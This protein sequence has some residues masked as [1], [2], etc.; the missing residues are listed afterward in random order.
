MTVVGRCVVAALA[1][2]CTGDPRVRV[3]AIEYGRS[4][5]FSSRQLVGDAPADERRPLSWQVWLI[6]TSD[7]TILVD[8]GF[9][10]AERAKA[11]RVTDFE[12]VAALVDP[13]TITDVIV[14]HGHWDHAGGVDQFPNA[15]VWIESATLRWMESRVSAAAPEASGVRFEDLEAIRHAKL[16]VIDGDAAVCPEVTIHRGGGHTPG[17]AWVEVRSDPPIVL[18]SDVAYLQEN[19]TRHVAPGGSMDPGADL[20]AYDAMNAIRGARFVPGHDPATM[21]GKKRVEITK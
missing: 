5:S 21:G 8:T 19:L 15:T 2:A 1:V 7:R 3:T 14:T 6:E 18:T 13:S 11:W 17:V 20:R 4:A 10:D 12:P 16:H 9:D